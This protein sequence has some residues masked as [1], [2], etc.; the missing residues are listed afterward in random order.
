MIDQSC[1]TDTGQ[2]DGKTKDRKFENTVVF[3]SCKRTDHVAKYCIYYEQYVGNHPRTS[4]SVSV[5][6]TA[7]AQENDAILAIIAYVAP[8]VSS[9]A[10]RNITNSNVERTSFGLPLLVM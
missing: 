10:A 9:G 4:C 8:A 3:G 6:M 7:E 2:S 5:P 1:N